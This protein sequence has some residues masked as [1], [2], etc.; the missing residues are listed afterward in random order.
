MRLVDVHNRERERAIFAFAVDDDIL[1][2]PDPESAVANLLDA[3]DGW[4]PCAIALT[5]TSNLGHAGGALVEHW[6]KCEVS[7]H[8]RGA[9]HLS[10]PER[11]IAS[12][13]Q[14]H[15]ERLAT[16]FRGMRPVPARAIRTVGERDR[17]GPDVRRARR[18][19]V[20]SRPRART[21]SRRSRA[22]RTQHT[23]N[24]D[25]AARPRPASCV[26]R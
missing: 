12:A 19:R 9:R 17:V 2:D 5:H 15:G 24:G 11:L 18:A 23:G 7:V 13:R 8:E 4:R 25:R 6:P 1:V 26:D 14:V 22:C 16:L 21:L 20:T 10:A 3:L